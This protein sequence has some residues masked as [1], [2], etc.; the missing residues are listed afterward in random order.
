MALKSSS[1]AEASKVNF[2]ATEREVDHNNDDEVALHEKSSIILE[3]FCL[4]ST[5]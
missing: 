1:S 2:V 3:P 4:D 5:F